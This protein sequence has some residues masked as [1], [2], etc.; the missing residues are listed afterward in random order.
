MKQSLLKKLWLR[1]SMLVAVILCGAT[2]AWGQDTAMP[3]K[4]EKGFYRIK[5][6]G[7]G[8]YVNVAGR[9]TVTFVDDATSATAAGSVLLVESNDK[10][11]VQILRSQG[12]DLPGYAERAMKYVP[13][14]VQIVV[15]KLHAEGP[16]EILGEHGL[17]AIMKKFDES[18]DYHL[19]TEEVSGGVRI[20]GKTPSMKPVVEFYRDNKA[21][22]DA[23]LPKI[24]Q[25]I[26]DAIQKILNK[27][28]GS[29]SS[30]LVPFSLETVWEKMGGKLTKPVDDPSKLSFL[31]EVLSDETNVWDFAYQTAM[32]YWKPLINH[33]KVKD[34]LS[35]LGDL[36]Q[37]VEKIEYIRPNFKYYIVQKD[38]K[39]DVISEG[40]VAVDADGSKWTLEGRDK[41]AVSFSETNWKWS[42]KDTKEYYTT[43]YTDFAYN[44]PV[45]VKA[46]TIPEIV[47]E[48]K[49]ERFFAKTN[50]I[51]GIVPAQTPVLLVSDDINNQELT[52]SLEDGTA[53]E[54]QLK[55]N[56][57]LI[58][59]YK[60][61]T[62]TVNKL[63]GVV[64]DLLKME[65][66]ENL[67]D[68]YVKEYEY[69]KLRNA[70][71]VNNKYF[72]GLS[73]DDI[74]VVDVNLCQLAKDETG[75]IFSHNL[76]QSA[77]NKAFIPSEND[78]I[79]LSIKGDVNRDGKISI[80]DVTALV[81]IIL[82]KDKPED[83]YDYEAARVNT[84]DDVISI[85]DVTALVNIILGK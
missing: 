20:Y 29:G 82:G 28:H 26:N 68:Q 47:K 46:Y 17:D 59:K 25:F 78:P 80:A 76:E 22:V 8:K 72:F 10:G 48:E 12:V 24:E 39:V 62:P 42:G 84:T 33:Q 4:I 38:G 75:L 21:N 55:G 23:K 74:A 64:H 32:I 37:Y 53:I 3:K 16:G 61:T 63:F 35:E 50:A 6:N 71:T 85:A 65:N 14:V 60:I 30:I 34:N 51:D 2:A 19:Y 45:G 49:T 7:N 70:G 83:G 18:F 36:A 13:K 40:N 9:K 67:Y 77:A 52:L 11:Q 79:Y 15:D 44:L 1:T 57:W 69:L 73:S 58:N 66:M 81:N 43:L 27:T 5:N 31:Q 41:F 54:S 56:D